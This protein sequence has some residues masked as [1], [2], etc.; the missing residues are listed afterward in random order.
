MVG[1]ES[2]LTLLCCFCGDRIEQDVLVEI[3][4]HAHGESQGLYAHKTCLVDRVRAE[5]PLHPVFLHD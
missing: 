5:I 2:P 4:I 1:N 3:E